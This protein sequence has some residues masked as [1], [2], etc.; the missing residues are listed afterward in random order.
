M[1]YTFGDVI[2]YIGT[3]TELDTPIG[4][5]RDIDLL[6]V[7]SISN[8]SHIS[9]TWKIIN[10]LHTKFNIL[11]DTRIYSNDQ[12]SEIPIVNRYLLR[13]FLNDLL[14]KNPFSDFS[15]PMDI[16]AEQCA[17]RI[18]K[19]ENKI[20]AIMPRIA[21]ETDQIRS[22]AQCVYDAIRAYL[23]L[24]LHPAASKEQAC[25]SFSN[26]YPE[27]SEANAI[28]EGYLDPDSI[29]DISNFIFDS[30]AV[31][32][33]LSLK[34]Q[35]K[36]VSDE[37]LLINTPSTS[38]AH[39]RD[40][41]LSYDHNMPLGL[42]CL[43]SYLTSHEYSAHILDAYAENLGVLSTVD[44]IFS[45][46]SVPKIIGLNASSPNIHI[47]H[48]IAWYIK[49]ICKEI[50]IVCGG[51]HA[52]LATE[53]TLSTGYIDF[54]VVGEGEI[55]FRELVRAIFNEEREEAKAIPGVFYSVSGRSIGTTNRK[56]FDLSQIPTP[57]FEHLPL[58]RYF[59]IKKRIYLHITR[60]C[61]FNCIYCSVPKFWGRQVR[62]IPMD[63]FLEQ[64]VKI[65]EQLKPEQVQ[66]VDDNFSHKRGK[67]IKAFCSGIKEAGLELKW[68]CQARADQLEA[69]IVEAMAQAGCF[70]IDLGIESGNAEIQKYI[71]K[72][73][74]LEKT[75]E[76]VSAIHSN[77]IFVKAFFMLGFPEESYAQI[78]DTI[79]YAINLKSGGLDDVAFFPVMPFPGTEISEITGKVVYQGAIIDSIDVEERSF[80]AHRL[81]K[82]SAKPEV[83]LNSR[84]TPDSLRY[85]VKFAY[86][87]FSHGMPVGDLEKEFE[88]Y[89]LIEESNI[90]GI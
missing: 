15:Q 7:F 34:A 79:N 41:Y 75:A 52:T 87:R 81:R 26:L 66:I 80:A 89:V 71:R 1:K 77:G 33:H 65:T 37:V 19:Q 31:V 20:V 10:K 45:R 59:N 6:V 27:F 78:S 23:V 82:Y 69:D 63:T 4:R 47:V 11:L 61:A 14:G 40:D 88:S 21:S 90:Y 64:L 25:V 70:E 17:Q 72:G 2:K 12:L 48:K 60:G 67:L 42:V 35:K 68:K 62:E 9:Y 55:A 86:Q 38:M 28:Y 43:V 16:I 32:K 74:N 36:V 58:D 49:R 76:I 51:P 30:L 5:L 54:A 8:E 24:D 46:E 85:L 56:T 3:T 18:N 44:R 83:S 73:L 22:I 50:V 53:H 57:D 29:V 39:P 84:F 13:T